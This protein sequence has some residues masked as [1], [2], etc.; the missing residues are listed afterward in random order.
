MASGP[1]SLKV[2]VKKEI[3]TCFAP[4]MEKSIGKSKKKKVIILQ[5]YKL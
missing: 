4:K 5:Y 2:R 3:F 1:A